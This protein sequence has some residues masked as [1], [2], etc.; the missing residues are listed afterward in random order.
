MR[1]SATRP[2]SRWSRTRWHRPSSRS[3]S[4]SCMA[5]A[6]PKPVSWSILGSQPASS[7]NRAPGI[8]IDGQR[9]GQ[10]R[11][12]AKTFLQENPDMA[13]R[14]EMVIR[15][16]AGLLADQPGIRRHLKARRQTTLILTGKSGCCRLRPAT[17]I[18]RGGVNSIPNEPHGLPP[19]GQP[20]PRD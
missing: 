14:A 6:S 4:T 13:Q 8:P 1:L 18:Q 5:K 7:K 20:H 2:G 10:G 16:N 19:W 3:S 15:Q 11:E 12:N 17:Q 9:I